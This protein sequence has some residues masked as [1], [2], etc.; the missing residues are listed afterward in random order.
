MENYPI[1]VRLRVANSS[2][3]CIA[4]GDT[5]DINNYCLVVKTRT[6]RHVI[7]DNDGACLELIL[8]RLG[9]AEPTIKSAM[10]SR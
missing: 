10:L 4:C 1:P 2:C 7:H 9:L 6:G 3:N 5:V 8:V